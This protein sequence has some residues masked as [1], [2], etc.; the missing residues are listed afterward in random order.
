MQAGT[1]VPEFEKLVLARQ[2]DHDPVRPLREVVGAAH[3]VRVVAA[4]LVDTDA[5]LDAVEPRGR[6]RDRESPQLDSDP[7]EP[8]AAP[9]EVGRRVQHA[10]RGRRDDPLAV[11]AHAQHGRISVTPARRDPWHALDQLDGHDIGRHGGTG[12]AVHARGDEGYRVGD[13][14]AF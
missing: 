12:I 3:E 14:P 2:E 8:Q 1:I 13:D 6:R 10:L 11:R 9:V 7:P 4:G 5:P